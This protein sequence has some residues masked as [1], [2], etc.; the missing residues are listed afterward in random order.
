MEMVMN[1]ENDWDVN[2]EGDALESP[3]VFVC[4]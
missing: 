2:V 3:V 1:E 4:R